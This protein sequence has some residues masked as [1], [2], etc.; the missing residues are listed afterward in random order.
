[1]EEFETDKILPDL[2]YVQIHLTDNII[3]IEIK[4]QKLGI[5]ETT[6]NSIQKSFKS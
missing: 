5:S 2:Y 4:L 1:M 3:L 6:N